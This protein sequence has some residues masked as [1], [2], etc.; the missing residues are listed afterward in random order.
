VRGPVQVRQGARLPHRRLI[1]GH[2]GI[3]QAYETGRGSLTVRARCDHRGGRAGREAIVVTEIPYQVNKA[4]LIEH[5]AELVREKKIEGISDIQDYSD[6][7]GMR[8]WI[9]VKRDA[10]A[11]VVL[12]T[13]YKMSD[14]QIT[15]G[16]NMIAIVQ[17]AAAGAEPARLP[18][19]LHRPPPHGRHPAL[20]LRAAGRRS[21]GGRS[22]RASGSRST[23]STASSPSSAARRTRT[24]RAWPCAPSRWRASPASSS[25]AAARRPRSRPRGPKPYR[26]NVRQAKAILDMRLQRL[27]GLERE[28][29]EGEYRELCGTISYL[30]SILADPTLLMSVIREELKAIGD[31]YGDARRTQIV[32]DEGE[33]EPIDLVADEPMIVMLTS[34]GYI[35]RLA[36][37]EYRVQGRGGVG[38]KGGVGRDATDYVTELFEAS[39][40]A[41]LLMFT[42][43]GACSASGCSSCRKAAA[44]APARPWSTSSTSARAS[45]CSAWSRTA[46]R[47]SRTASTT[48]S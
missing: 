15:F 6:R 22:S 5:I 31:E 20:A 11:Q 25:A 35:K 13:L 23:R 12:N 47:T 39:A 27:T 44:T 3:R 17:G 30:E 34:N 14:L 36:S 7:T 18:R 43:T 19:G 9:Q 4:K 24:R 40:H 37:V 8:I 29:V 41:N 2:A 45:A 1:H 21:S 38:V 26:L 32:E 46:R 33:I 16:V 10:A 42:N 48:S 28:K